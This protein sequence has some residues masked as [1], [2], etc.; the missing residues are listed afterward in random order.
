MNVDQNT[1]NHEHS[2][3]FICGHTNEEKERISNSH[4]SNSL[5][6]KHTKRQ[7]DHQPR[8]STHHHHLYPW[9]R[10]CIRHIRHNTTTTCPTTSHRYPVI[11]PPMIQS[12]KSVLMYFNSW[13]LFSNRPGLAN[14]GCYT[15]TRNIQKIRSDVCFLCNL[16]QVRN[17]LKAIFT[18]CS[19]AFLSNT[20][21]L[22]LRCSVQ[23]TWLVLLPAQNPRR[24]KGGE[25]KS[26]II[27]T[28]S[29]R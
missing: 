17:W 14:E 29:R 15:Q 21:P 27:L 25:N 26:N 4:N 22:E 28:V 11:S 8:P 6:L 13:H 9:D 18:H 5:L 2:I 12:R 20:I 3:P 7:M 24:G 1:W 10:G 19:T 16:T 23:S